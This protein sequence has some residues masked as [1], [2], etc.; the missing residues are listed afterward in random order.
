MVISSGERLSF[1]LFLAGLVH[2][3]II[4]GVGFDIAPPKT[5]TRMLEIALIKNPNPSEPTKADFLAQENQQGSGDNTEIER[6]QQ[7]TAPQVVPVERPA[8][9]SK[10]QSAKSQNQKA[11]TQLQSEVVMA[12]S[13]KAVP[14]QP[15]KRPTAEELMRQ[16]QEIARQISDLE[17]FKTSESRRPRKLHINSINA[18]KSIAASYEAAWQQKVERIGNLNYP[19]DIRRRQLSGSLILS[20]ELDADGNLLKIII[21]RRS[22]YKAID[23]AAVNIVKMASPFAPFSPDLRKEVDVLVITRTWQF[24]NEGALRAR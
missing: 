23:D 14:D 5:M 17:S 3:V 11:L 9:Q 2:A 12:V 18:Q 10:D 20:V 13:P 19:G 1:T 21:N 7:A 22:G 16:R 24:L 15:T 4:L 6:A 8:L